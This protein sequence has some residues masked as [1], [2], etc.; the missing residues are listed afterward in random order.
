MDPFGIPTGYTLPTTD[1]ID[2]YVT[3]AENLGKSFN[4]LGDDIEAGIAK[5]QQE[6][7]DD[8]TKGVRSLPLSPADMAGALKA[9]D[10]QA[11]AEAKRFREGLLTLNDAAITEQLRQLHTANEKIQ[12]LVKVYPSPQALLSSQHLGDPKRTE[13]LNQ[14][15]SAGTAGVAGMARL[16]I[17]TGNRALAA[18]VQSRLEVM[19][20][21]D[22]PFSPAEFADRVV[23]AEHAAFVLAAK[24]T[25][26]AFQTA[27]N[28]HRALQ[29]G[30]TDLHEKMKGA[31][32]ADDI[33]RREPAAE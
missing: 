20:K 16:A 23:G 7:Y 33:A 19:P 9:A 13:Y 1:E 17:A 25:A 11:K 26:H 32:R 27:I 31:L 22:R 6:I 5:R 2:G 21:G 10:M 28:R 15:A 14:I 24:K 18:A 12:G 8:T 4:A 30:K 29:K 3:K